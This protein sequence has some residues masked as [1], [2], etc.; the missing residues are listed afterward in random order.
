MFEIIEEVTN[1]NDNAEYSEVDSEGDGL[2][3]SLA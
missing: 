3:D 1:E 2:E